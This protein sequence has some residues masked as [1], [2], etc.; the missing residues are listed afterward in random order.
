MKIFHLSNSDANGGAARAANRIHSALVKKGINSLMLVNKK[1][2]NDENIIEPQDF[3]EKILV[4]L[5]LYISNIL[6]KFLKTH[7]DIPYSI[8]LFPSSWINR[9]NKSDADIVHL[10]WVQHEMLSISDIGKIEKPIV[11]TLHDMWAFCGAEH[12]A[13]DDRWRSGYQKK[14]NIISKYVID[15]DRWTWLRKLKHWK[16]KIHIVTPSN[17]LANCVRNS[18][19]MRNWPVTVIP[20]LLNTD[21]WKPKDKNL[22][23][24]LIG[25]PI[26][27]PLAIFGSL[28]ANSSYNK[29]FDLLAETLNFIKKEGNL[30]NMKVVVFGKNTFK[31]LPKLNFPLHFIGHLDD[32]SLVNLYSAADVTIIPSRQEAFCQIASESQACGTPVVAFNIGGL[33][34]IV[35]HLNTGYLAKPFDIEDLSKGI[36]WVLEK[37]QRLLIGKETRIRT[38]KKFSQEL[39]IKK[40]Q[41]VYEKVLKN[42]NKE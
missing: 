41:S 4:K 24:K 19:L 22:A 12:L 15:L 31:S 3:I 11:W 35:D 2:L 29:G 13:Q 18:K 7:K 25:L 6:I 34:D 9:I 10:H 20:N 28:G 21:S 8:S 1:N 33:T 37:K 40:Y 26:D 23:R 38:V 27:V 30:K 5:R 39:L 17:W 42:E 14:D 16:K 36:S 32:E